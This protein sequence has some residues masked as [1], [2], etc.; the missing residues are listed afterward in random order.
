[1]CSLT[2]SGIRC[3]GFDDSSNGVHRGGKQGLHGRE[4]PLH[5][6]IDLSEAVRFSY[7]LRRALDLIKHHEWH[8]SYSLLC[9]ILL[10]VLYRRIS[11][12]SEGVVDGDIFADVFR[13]L[14]GLAV[15]QC[16]ELGYHRSVRRIDSVP[17]YLRTELRRRVFWSAYSM[18]CASCIHLGRPLS[19]HA[20]EIDAEVGT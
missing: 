14:A 11:L 2:M 6:L 12:A 4:N 8:T 5:S 17:N 15:R 13:K 16:V 18:E 1:M 19:L 10:A 7:V 3:R 20:N 9:C